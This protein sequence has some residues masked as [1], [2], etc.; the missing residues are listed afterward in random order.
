MP[1]RR[2]LSGLRFGR[3]LVIS[4]SHTDNRN[5]AHWHCRCDCTAIVVVNGQ[6][7]VNNETRSCGC[8]RREISRRRMTKHGQSS[9]RNGL[10]PSPEYR[11]WCAM[12][13][14]CYNPNAFGYEYYGGCGIIVCDRWRQSFEAFFK[15]MG[16]RPTL[17]HTLDRWPN[18]YGNYEP[19]NC[20]WA[21][22]KEQRHNRRKS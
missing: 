17:Q 12:L 2:M 21:T 22:W 16:P 14:R 6:R 18:P 13:R 3:L 11:S 19:D 9:T 10:Q 15:D 20:R 1:P 7:L 5:Y 4:F 8:L